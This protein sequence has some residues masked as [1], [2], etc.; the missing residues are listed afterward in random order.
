[1]VT[2]LAG[3]FKPRL[4]AHQNR[5]MQDFDADWIGTF[6][7]NKLASQ[8]KRRAPTLKPS[9]NLLVSIVGDLQPMFHFVVNLLDRGDGNAMCDAILFCEAAGVY[10]P[11]FRLHISQSE[12]EINSRLGSGFDLRKHMLAI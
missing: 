1:M 12:A 8:L 9:G 11:S 3:D 5:T 7:I 6:R 10:Q 4:A 2:G